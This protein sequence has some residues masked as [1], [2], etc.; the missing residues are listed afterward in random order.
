MSPTV[1]L[2]SPSSSTPFHLLLLLLL[3]LLLHL[4]FLCLL[5]LTLP[6]VLSD[7]LFTLSIACGPFIPSLFLLSPTRTPQQ[8]QQQPG[9]ASNSYPN[10]IRNRTPS[11]R[12]PNRSM[13]R[14]PQEPLVYPCF[15]LTHAQSLLS[16]CSHGSPPSLRPPVARA[17]HSSTLVSR[18]RGASQRLCRCWGGHSGVYTSDQE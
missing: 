13:T 9:P 11:S 2:P 10:Q 16:S 14:A 7:C 17:F 1:P 5:L 15:A 18:G 3:L 12:P 8:Q 4:F 6:C